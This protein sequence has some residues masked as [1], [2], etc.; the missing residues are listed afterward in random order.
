MESP[1]KKFLERYRH[2]IPKSRII[3]ERV[4][5]VLKEEC[6]ISLEEN[7]INVRNSIVYLRIP[8]NARSIIYRKKNT[9]I[10]NINEGGKVN[11]EDIR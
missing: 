1:L 7:Q 10:K 11:I 4:V 3:K 5:E 8:S 6:N 2:L 9:L